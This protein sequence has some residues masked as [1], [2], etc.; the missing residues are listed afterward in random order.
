[1]ADWFI[2][3]DNEVGET[4]PL[5][6]SELLQRVRAGQVTE[7]TRLRKD[8]SAWFAAAEVG[9]LFEAASRPKVEYVCPNCDRVIAKPPTVCRHCAGD[10]H[11][12]IERQVAADSS[13]EGPSGKRKSVKNW[14][15]KKRLARD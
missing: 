10:I 11:H 5:T 9:G 7:Q 15:L 6:P 13:A 3:N 8:D 2:Q 1:M 12:A 14:L 4:G